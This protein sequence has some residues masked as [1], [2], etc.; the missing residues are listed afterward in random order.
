MSY[1]RC[2]RRTETVIAK[3]Q[4]TA[5]AQFCLDVSNHMVCIYTLSFPTTS[6]CLHFILELFM[7]MYIHI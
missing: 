5:I 1:T 6:I 7:E 2:M 4:H 3:G